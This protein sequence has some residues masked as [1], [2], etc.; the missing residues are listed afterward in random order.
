ME[1]AVWEDEGTLDWVLRLATP[2]RHADLLSLNHVRNLIKTGSRYQSFPRDTVVGTGKPAQMQGREC[3][4][5]ADLHLQ[6]NLC[7]HC[8][9]CDQ[10]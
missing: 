3:G 8:V 7:S 5:H 6:G 10:L 1:G 2:C 9:Q 4:H